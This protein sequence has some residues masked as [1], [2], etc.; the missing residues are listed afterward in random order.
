MTQAGNSFGVDWPYVQGLLGP[1]GPVLGPRGPHYNLVG[2]RDSNF[3]LVGSR[4]SNYNLVGSRDSDFHLAGSRSP[5]FPGAQSPEAIEWQ[6]ALTD[7]Q[8]R[9]IKNT[10]NPFGISE[11][12]MAKMYG[13]GLLEARAKGPLSFVGTKGR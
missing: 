12:T 7:L 13:T 5:D 8:N 10:A 9:P 6:K 3:N 2:S 11:D 4:D 1:R